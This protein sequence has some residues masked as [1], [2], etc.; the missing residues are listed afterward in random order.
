MY[1]IVVCDLVIKIC[2]GMEIEVVYIVSGNP[3]AKY[4]AGRKRRR[5]R[6]AKRACCCYLSLIV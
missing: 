5:T 4:L 2:N 1:G 3:M 6:A